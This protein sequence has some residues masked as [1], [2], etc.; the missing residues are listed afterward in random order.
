MSK[1][2]IVAFIMIGLGFLSTIGVDLP[3][4]TIETLLTSITDNA[5]EVFSILYGAITL[6]LRKITDSPLADGV[7]GW[8]GFKD[9]SN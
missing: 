2:A 4:E 7:R 9:G 5:F 3:L 8:L 6:W 1:T